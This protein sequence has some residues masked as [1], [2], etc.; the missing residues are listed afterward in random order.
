MNENNEQ[1]REKVKKGPIKYMAGN[2]VAANL[3]LLFLLVGGFLFMTQVKQE[4]FPDFDID[5][6]NV[7]VAYPGA[8]PEEVEEGIVLAIEEAVRGIDGIDEITASS[9]EAFGSVSIEL[10]TGVDEQR[11]YQDVKQEVDRITSFPEE[12]EEPQVSIA[13]GQRKVLS[14]FLYGDL[15][16]KTLYSL[17]ADTRD[18]LLQT[19]IADVRIKGDRPREISIEVP[20]EELRRYNL[21]LREIAGKV[22]RT[23]L[24]LGGGDIET[25]SEEILLRVKER[26]DYGKEFRDIPIIVTGDGSSVKL[27]D[28]AKIN[29]GFEDI[30]KFPTYNGKRAMRLDVYRV[31]EQTPL[32]IA[33]IV[34]GFMDRMKRELPS[35][36]NIS[37][38]DDMSDVYRERVSLLFR[39]ASMGLV[40][41]LL[42]LGL[43]LEARLAFWVAVGIAASFLGSFVFLPFLG[44]SINMVSLFAFILALGVVVDDAIVVGENIYEY[45]QKDMSYFEAAVQGARDVAMPV[46]FGVL[47]NLVA[48][49][50]LLFVPG[51]MGKVFKTI[52]VVVITVF[53]ISLFESLFV[54]PEHL[55]HKGKESTGLIAFIGKYRQKF[56][57][58]FT[59]FLNTKYEPFL[60]LCLKNK[61]IVIAISVSL[62][63]ITIGFVKS[64]RLG[65]EM[66]PKVQM[67]TAN[68]SVQLPVGSPV[69]NTLEVRDKLIQSAKEAAKT[70][71][72]DL[73]KGTF[74]KVGTISSGGGGPTPGSRTV[75]AHLLDMSVFLGS[76]EKRKVSTNEFKNLWIQKTGEIPEVESF[77]FESDRGGPGAGD[78][79][80]IEFS[81]KNTGILETAAAGAAEKLLQYPQVVSTDD[82]FTRGKKQY[83]F[84]ILPAGEAM[85][86]SVSSLADQIRGSFYGTE[87]TRQLRGRD[88]VKIM[89]RSPEKESN[90]EYFLEEFLVRTPQ[91]TFVPLKEIA[92]ITKDRAY[93]YISRRKGRRTMTVTARVEPSDKSGQV[94]RKF[95]EDHLKDLK[96]QYRTLDYRYTGKQEE[97][98]EAMSSLAMNFLVVLLIIYSLL[99]IPFRS[100]I[101]PLIIMIA[102]PFGI[103]GAILGH[104]MLGYALSVMSMMGVMA[105]TGVVVNDSIVLIEYTNRLKRRGHSAFEAIK[106]AGV[107]RF[108]PI[109]MTSLTTFGGLAPMIFETSVQAKFL[110]PMAISLGIGVLFVTPLCLLLIPCL[111][112]EARNVKLFLRRIFSGSN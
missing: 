25:E 38:E 47:T 16:E 69:E 14:I 75:G 87:I 60:N 31:G 58:G 24:E 8:T 2:N 78:D 94:I 112:L 101:Q 85:G 52:P 67:D 107:R 57:R 55:N 4:V 105:L 7:S 64:G 73:I 41:I 39:N 71:D 15:N 62:L 109:L 36:V 46:T 45:R 9:R 13:G 80:S 27:G 104:L 20:Q 86:I 90:S 76:E 92:G 53:L 18:M 51:I 56:D 5:I 88:E 79:I 21:T 72:S 29:D 23:S 37:V 35:S 54:L 63:I 111:Y 91:G 106:T 33:D 40:L 89:V 77:T 61:S 1:K 95:E 42:I 12:A 93:N 22:R 98:R 97:S 65:F 43:F 32:E 3:L 11:V 83:D 10:I 110:V 99:G 68:V 66:M 103:I 19:K 28:I 82:G 44:V 17:T 6:V 50:P 26:R 59:K 34:S 48:F 96:N 100:Y 30:E 84:K 70:Y 49:S 81:H 108:R 102:I 74:S